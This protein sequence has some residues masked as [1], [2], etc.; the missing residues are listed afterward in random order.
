MNCLIFY[1]SITNKYWFFSVEWKYNDCSSSESDGENEIPPP[2]KRLGTKRTANKKSTKS[3]YTS[4]ESSADTDDDKRRGASRRTAA[5]SI[6]YK[7]DT[8]EK[9]DSEDLLEVEYAEAADT[10][11]EEKC[12]T[13]EK[14]LGLRQGK[15]GGNSFKQI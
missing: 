5:T 4:E 12:E 3:R 14:I 13:I 7:E 11:P 10:I 1:L 9:T 15:K 8:D 2:S 6:S